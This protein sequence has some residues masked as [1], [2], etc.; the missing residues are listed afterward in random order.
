[1]VQY[2]ANTNA[3]LNLDASAMK[4]ISTFPFQFCIFA[5]FFQI[6]LLLVLL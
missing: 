5:V 3:L 2:G 1:M 4:Y 6:F